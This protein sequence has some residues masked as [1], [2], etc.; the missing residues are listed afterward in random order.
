MI[1]TQLGT[2]DINTV[3]L[4]QARISE[5]SRAW[6]DSRR[7]YTDSHVAKQSVQQ[8]SNLLCLGR[9]PPYGDGLCCG[10]RVILGTRH[11][12]PSLPK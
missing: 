2:V 8:V 11:V 4:P 9:L 6:L 5:I 7:R 3:T 12:N 10:H 1:A